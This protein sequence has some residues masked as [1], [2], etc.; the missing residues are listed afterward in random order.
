MIEDEAKH[1]VD[2]VRSQE[3]AKLKQQSREKLNA[4]SRKQAD[5]L[6]ERKGRVEMLRRE[7]ETRKEMFAHIRDESTRQVLR[8]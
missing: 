2:I 6:Q 7:L 5:E 1:A 4:L 8:S 3:V